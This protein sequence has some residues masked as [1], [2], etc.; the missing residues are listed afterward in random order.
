MPLSSTELRLLYEAFWYMNTFISHHC[1]SERF[2]PSRVFYVQSLCSVQFHVV[3]TSCL[4]WWLPHHLD[5]KAITR[6]PGNQR[7]HIG[8]QQ[9]TRRGASLSTAELDAGKPGALFQDVLLQTLSVPVTSAQTLVHFQNTW[10][11]VALY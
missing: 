4:W 3:S 2:L 7:C 10:R 8:F 9:E 1:C 5:R 6:L 11:A